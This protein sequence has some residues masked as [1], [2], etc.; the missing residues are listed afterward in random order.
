V[1][2]GGLSDAAAAS[3]LGVCPD[4]TC[5]CFGTAPGH[6]LK[7]RQAPAEARLNDEAGHG[8]HLAQMASMTRL[9]IELGFSWCLSIGLARPQRLHYSGGHSVTEPA[10]RALL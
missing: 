1:G 2:S 5:C 8:V 7:Y 10:L 3:A 9:V 4:E 6:Y